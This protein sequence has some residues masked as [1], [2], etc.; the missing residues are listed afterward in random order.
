MWEFVTTEHR[1]LTFDRL[2]V[3]EN[4]SFVFEWLHMHSAVLGRIAVENDSNAGVPGL[5]SE[6]A[7]AE[8][9]ALIRSISAIF[10]LHSETVPA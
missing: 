3:C 8:T 10:H 4:D 2:L 7:F 5:G 1:E 6:L 9:I